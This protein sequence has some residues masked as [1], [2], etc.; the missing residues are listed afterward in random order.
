MGKTVGKR[1]M[2]DYMWCKISQVITSPFSKIAKWCEYIRPSME[3]LLANDKMQSYD[4]HLPSLHIGCGE[5]KQAGCE[6]SCKI[7]RLHHAAPRW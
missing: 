6:S 2:S 3:I 5:G 4:F 7:S 1:R